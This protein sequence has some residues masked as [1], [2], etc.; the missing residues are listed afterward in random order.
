MRKNNRLSFGKQI[1]LSRDSSVFE[2]GSMLTGGQIVTVDLDGS[3]YKILIG[4]GFLDDIGKIIKNHFLGR[5]VII[6]SDKNV[7]E[8]YLEKTAEILKAS[9]IQTSSIV[10]PAG[11]QAKSFST[12]QFVAEKILQQGVERNSIVLAFGGGVIGDLAGFVA[13]VILRGIRVIQIPTT[14]LAQVDSSVG[15]KTGINVS[16]GKNLVGTFYQP[17]MV[18]ADTNTLKTLSQ[19]EFRAGYAELVKYGLINNAEFF[20]WLEK[21]HQEIFSCQTETIQAISQACQAK[22][23]FVQDDQFEKGK[24]ALLNL[25]HTFAHALEGAVSYD[26]KRLIHGEAVAIGMIL[27]FGFSVQMNLAP[28]EDYNRVLNHLKNV[29]LPVSIAEIE[30][31]KV[32]VDILMDYMARDKKVSN[33]TLTF[34]LTRGIGQAFIAHKIDADAVYRFLTVQV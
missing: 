2:D 28:I 12:F 16:S 9:S 24:R 7:A 17:S 8:L 29:G 18:L 34:I 27:A 19:R 1:F 26:T 10:V 32:S 33:N 30:G 21:N 25:G 3:G 6:I 22:R 11:E 13:S 5:Q 14:L 23:R 31:A 20:S 4:S 15:G